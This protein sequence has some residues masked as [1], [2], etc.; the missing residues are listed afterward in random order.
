[1]LRKAA[2][3][4]GLTTPPDGGLSPETTA[5]RFIAVVVVVAAGLVVEGAVSSYIGAARTP[6]TD[7]SNDEKPA[8]DAPM[9]LVGA[10][11][12]SGFGVY[13]G[14]TNNDDKTVS[15]M[16]GD[17]QF[18]GPDF[19]HRNAS[20]E[21]QYVDPGK[22]VATHVA[23]A[24]LADPTKVLLSSRDEVVIRSISLC[25]LGRTY[26]R[27]CSKFIGVDPNSPVHVVLKFGN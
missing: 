10:S 21:V 16:A 20:F 11:Y 19:R 14:L 6:A 17:I 5:R 9:F 15:L 12:Q 8:P 13:L 3:I 22:F 7:V 4:L 18:V 1:M 25:K 23:D 27:G 26:Y 24:Q 2:R